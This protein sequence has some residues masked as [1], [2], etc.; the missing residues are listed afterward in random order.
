MIKVMAVLVLVLAHVTAKEVG[1]GGRVNREKTKGGNKTDIVEPY[2]YLNSGSFSGPSVPDSPDPLVS[3][4]W[5][6]NGI[7]SISG[8]KEGGG[9]KTEGEE[10]KRGSGERGKKRERGKRIEGVE[11]RVE[12]REGEKSVERRG[13]K[14]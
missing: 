7:F 6:S 9:R 4:R 10:E 1:R 11:G 3:Y 8:R 5:N 2:A 12:R 13:M 14:G